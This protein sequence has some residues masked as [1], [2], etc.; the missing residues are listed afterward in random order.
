MHVCDLIESSRARMNSLARKY[1]AAAALP[2]G[3][4]VWIEGMGLRRVNDR[5]VGPGQID[6]VVSSTQEALSI[7]RKKTRVL[8]LN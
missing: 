1:G 6:V 4:V 8:I 3:T 5:G 7:G 2:F